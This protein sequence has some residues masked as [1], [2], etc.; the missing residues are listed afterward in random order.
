MPGFRQQAVIHASPDAVFAALAD[1]AN[2]IRLHA[3][4]TRSEVVGGGPLKNGSMLHRVR[5]VD[6]RTVDAEFEVLCFRPGK[7]LEISGGAQGITA[8]WRWKLAPA[9]APEGATDVALDVTVEGDGFAMF[10]AG[11]VTDALRRAEEDHLA[12]LASLVGG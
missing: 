7:E 4:M 8:T 12:R 2:G 5:T 6:G 10:L 1:A 3:G 11:A 9:A